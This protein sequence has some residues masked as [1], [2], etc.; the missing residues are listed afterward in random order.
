MNAKS[1]ENLKNLTIYFGP[2]VKTKL[3]L[4]L[5]TI[6]VLLI[7]RF[8]PIYI[9]RRSKMTLK[10]KY[11]WK[12]F[13]EY[14][15]VTIGLI[16]IGRIW[17]EGVQSLVTFFGLISAGLA[18]AL[19][20]VVTDIAGWAFLI[21][22]R[23]FDLGD[24]IQIGKFSGDVVDIRP[25]KFSI[26]EIGNWVDADQSTGRVIHIPNSRIF[27]E[28]IINYTREFQF[29]WN[30]IPVL[31]TF[32]SNWKEAKKILKKIGEK[33][34]AKLAKKA[35]EEIKKAAKK[36]LIYYGV[37]TPIVY[38]K[39]VDSGVRLTIRYLCPPRQRRITEEAIWEDILSAFKK[40][41]DIDLAYPTER[42]YMNKIEGKPGTGGA[43]NGP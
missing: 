21:T 24:R 4:T 31:I 34:G 8:I 32:E 10:T 37:L 28:E 29:I 33:H 3:I 15:I 38:T 7:L 12:K 16:I 9:I 20:D 30:E 14:I 27:S 42:F 17:I 22:R 1:L 35:E 43:K 6:A 19:K 25:F 40:R 23:P 18:I 11:R 41:N 5:I 36:Y 13:T 26:I 39:V 2:D